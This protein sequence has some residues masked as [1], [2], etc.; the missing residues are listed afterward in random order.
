MTPIESRRKLLEDI[1]YE[2]DPAFAGTPL[3]LPSQPL[4]QQ[5]FTDV[6]IP[7]WCKAVGLLYHINP[8]PDPAFR[9][10]TTIIFRCRAKLLDNCDEDEL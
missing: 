3:E 10:P 6:T 2:P 7:E 5:C 1:L 4:I 8:R 9:S